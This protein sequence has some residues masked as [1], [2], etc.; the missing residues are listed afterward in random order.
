[1]TIAH[2]I[3]ICVGLL[4]VTAIGWLVMLVLWLIGQAASRI[5]FGSWGIRQYLFR[6]S[7]VSLLIVG[8]ASF[9]GIWLSEVDVPLRARADAETIEAFRISIIKESLT[10]LFYVFVLMAVHVAWAYLC[11]VFGLL[12]GK[13]PVSRRRTHREILR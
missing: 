3:G 2:W 1:M 12:T 9:A 13:N 8:L 5:A 6:W 4:A 11:L 7:F 10:L